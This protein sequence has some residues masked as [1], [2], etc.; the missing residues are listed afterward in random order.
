MEDDHQSSLT[1]PKSQSW[2]MFDTIS[3]KYDLLNRVLSFG[4]DVGWRKRLTQHLPQKDSL[5]VL[6]I[7]TGT[8]DVLITLVKKDSRITEAVGIDLAKQMLSVG[9]EKILK[10]KLSE[11]I[12][13]YPA[14]AQELPF[15][16]NTF[17]AV[18]ISFGIR[19]IPNLALALKEKYRVLTKNGKVIILEF[20]LPE[21]AII[22]F[23]NILYLRFGVPFIGFLFTGNY[24]AY[25]YLNQTIEQFPYGK[26]FCRILRQVGFQDVKA[27]SLF[28]G[29]A[30]IYEGVK[31]DA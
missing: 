26:Q 17:D 20:S 31:T 12:K 11:K 2:Q 27:T 13:L 9:E 5:K 4:L 6:D 8:A 1:L 16:D 10:K 28:M 7:A 25:K 14:D 23:F 29:A 21:N 3:S 22:R 19:N 18:T 30:T 24:K 15:D